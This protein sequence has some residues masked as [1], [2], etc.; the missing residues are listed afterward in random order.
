M[1][2]NAADAIIPKEKIV[3]Y[4]LSP[5]HPSG[6]LKAK[7]FRA[8]GY[9]SDQWEA[10]EADIRSVLQNRAIRKEKT[11]YGQKYEVSEK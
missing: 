9:S 5:T 8:I 11:D 10:L 4:L 1:I 2:L 3:D 6:H 7:Y